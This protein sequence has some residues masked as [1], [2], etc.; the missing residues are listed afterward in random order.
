[1]LA[2]RMV[3]KVGKNVYVQAVQQA[4]QQVQIMKAPGGVQHDAHLGKGRVV[5]IPYEGWRVHAMSGSLH[6]IQGMEEIVRQKIQKEL[7]GGHIS[8]PTNPS[9]CLI[10]VI[11]VSGVSAQESSRGIYT[12]SSSV[13]P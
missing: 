2:P 8:V 6:S 3:Q 10:Y 5:R 11:W 7:E 9:S 4:P 1:M 13:L 12:Y